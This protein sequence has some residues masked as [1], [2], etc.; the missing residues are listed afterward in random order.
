MELI[1]ELLFY[2]G[3]I[4]F[5]SATG[6]MAISELRKYRVKNHGKELSR[7]IL[8]HVDLKKE[9]FPYN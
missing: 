7:S 9:K 8:Q 5:F 6:M 2:L 1:I 4:S 3:V